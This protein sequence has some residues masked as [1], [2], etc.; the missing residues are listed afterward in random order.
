MDCSTTRNRA[1]VFVPIL[2]LATL[3]A[4]PVV[5]GG[6]SPEKGAI[7]RTIREYVADI[8]HGDMKA[9]VAACARRASVVDGFP[10]YAWQTCRSWWKSYIPNDRSLGATLG[11]LSIGRLVYGEVAHHHAYF[12]YPAT[13]TDTQRGNSVVYKGIGTLTL[14]LTRC[15]RLFTG[16]AWA[17]GAN[18]LLAR[19]GA[20]KGG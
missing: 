12:I 13:F 1:A 20:G 19:S 11:T 2:A 16:S 8:N 15:R 3:N 7:E 18:T 10:P 17:W 14:K 4:S 6:A 9:I 5:A